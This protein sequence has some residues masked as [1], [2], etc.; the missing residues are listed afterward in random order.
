MLFA[1]K[2]SRNNIDKQELAG[3]P[4]KNVSLSIDTLLNT[5]NY[6]A[7]GKGCANIKVIKC[8]ELNNFPSFTK[9]GN[10][11]DD[12]II[13][14]DV[15]LEHLRL[16]RKYK[17][18]TSFEDYKVDVYE[19]ELAEPDFESNL[20]A[21]LFITR[22]KE[23]CAEGINFA[24]HCTLITWGCGSPC[25]QGVV[26][27]RKTGKIFDDYGTSLGSEFRKDSKMIITN[28]EAIDFETNLIELCPYCEVAHQI[29]TGTEFITIE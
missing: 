22:I 3:V 6:L 5:E 11:K 20:S 23:G 9:L 1:C 28:V 7:L 8:D 27:D 16:F 21:R 29:W 2:P 12:L 25:Q 15:N 14:K 17:P 10:Y 13:G 26:V 18:K 19:G 24:G 4:I